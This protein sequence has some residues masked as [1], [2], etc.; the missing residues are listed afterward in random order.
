MS[1]HRDIVVRASI[2]SAVPLTVCAQSCC[3]SA[4][5]LDDWGYLVIDREPLTQ[6]VMDHA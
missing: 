6:E 5:G 4:S 2:R 3:R 1:R